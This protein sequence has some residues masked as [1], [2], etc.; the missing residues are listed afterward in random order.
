M[1]GTRRKQLG[2]STVAIALTI[3]VIGAIAATELL[4]YQRNKSTS[5]TNTSQI[6]NQQKGTT[7]TQS[8][9]DPYAGWN[10][11]TDNTSGIS[12]KYPSGWQVK[13]GGKN[14]AWSIT[15]ASNPQNS[16]TAIYVFSDGSRTAQQE[17]EACYATDACLG[18]L[19]I[20]ILT[21][22]ESTINGLNAFMATMQNSYGTYHVTVI[23]GN[24]PASQGIPYVVIT[25]YTTDQTA[26]N[27][28]SAIMASATFPN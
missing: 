25:T 16:I 18:S 7:T 3:L 6:T 20:K 10:T 28:F 13:A 4:L 19:D 27:I 11:F 1:I 21:G 26:L 22:S 14:T 8:S 5:T 2:F 24:K 17:W 15:Q 23:R 9:A 12:I